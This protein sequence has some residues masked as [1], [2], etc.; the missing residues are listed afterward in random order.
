MDLIFSTNKS[1][2]SNCWVGPSLYDTCNHSFISENITSPFHREIWDCNNAHDW[3]TERSI[4]SFNWK[5]F[6]QNNNIT[7]KV[8]I[9]NETLRNIFSDYIPNKKVK[10]D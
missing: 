4:T 6:F 1:L 5:K 7:A 3:T 8:E 9:F 10:L 2:L